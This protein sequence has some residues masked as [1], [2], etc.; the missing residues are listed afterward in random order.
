MALAERELEAIEGSNV[1]SLVYGAPSLQA[2]LVVT[3]SSALEISESEGVWTVRDRETGIY[4]AGS[5][6]AEALRDFRLALAEH[7]DVLERQPA[8]SSDLAAQLEYLRFHLG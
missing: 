7:R 6:D 5:T 4:G 3:V 2:S 1:R 8:L